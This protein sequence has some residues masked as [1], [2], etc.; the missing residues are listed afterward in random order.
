MGFFSSA[1]KAMSKGLKHM[2]AEQAREQK[3]ID[4]S[5]QVINESLALS[6]TSS[7]SATRIS[8]YD[9]AMLTLKRLI[10]NHSIAGDPKAWKAQ[11]D[12]LVAERPDFIASVVKQAMELGNASIEEAKTAKTKA[13]RAQKLITSLSNLREDKDCDREGIT[14]AIKRLKQQYPLPSV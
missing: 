7:K 9:V 1:M 11:H 2:A 13:N 3:L 10:D 5:M 4:R 6:R 8:R 14:S 12:K